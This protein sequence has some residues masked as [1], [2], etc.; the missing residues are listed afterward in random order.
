V[1]AQSLRL[2]SQCVE[3]LDAAASSEDD[4]GSDLQVQ[5]FHALLPEMPQKSR[6]W[7]WRSNQRPMEWSRK[8]ARS[9]IASEPDRGSSISGKPI[10]IRNISEV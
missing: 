9:A 3:L 1:L 7:V 6:R 2:L 4:I 5:R 10:G 8:H